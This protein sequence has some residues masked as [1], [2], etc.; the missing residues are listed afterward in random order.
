MAFEK[1][2]PQF[3]KKMKASLSACRASTPQA[4]CQRICFVFFYTSLPSAFLF[5]L[6]LGF[7][8]FTPI[9]RNRYRLSG[10]CWSRRNS[11]ISKLSRMRRLSQFISCCCGFCL[12]AGVLFSPKRRKNLK[13]LTNSTYLN[14][15]HENKNLP[16]RHYNKKHLY[17]K[18]FTSENLSK[19]ESK[20][21]KA[22]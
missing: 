3:F 20:K 18:R 17:I 1:F 22:K 5:C 15:W 8:G 16:L 2:S 7:C 9:F 13:E 4:S 11:R 21:K 12:C 6:L 10:V 19:E 14:S